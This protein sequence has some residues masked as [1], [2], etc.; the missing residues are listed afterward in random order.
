[1]GHLSSSEW[2]VRDPR[3]G[4]AS[5]AEAVAPC[6]TAPTCEQAGPTR[7]ICSRH[8]A[9]P[10]L[11]E[12]RKPMRHVLGRLQQADSRARAQSCARNGVRPASAGRCDS[13]AKG[14]AQQPSKMPSSSPRPRLRSTQRH[15]AVHES[16][17]EHWDR[18]VQSECAW[19]ASRGA[20]TRLR[21]G[22]RVETTSRRQRAPGIPMTRAVKLAVCRAWARLVDAP[23]CTWVAKAACRS[24]LLSSCGLASSVPAGS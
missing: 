10:A 14:W 3:H 11:V 19:R 6:A 4:T 13:A 9:H 17:C 7:D 16:A 2:R 15:V 24:T 18:C 21:Y 20:G 1:M 12:L 22:R 5:T 23:P 8:S